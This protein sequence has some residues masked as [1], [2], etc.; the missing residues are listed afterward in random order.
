MWELG[1][2]CI[3]YDPNIHDTASKF[4]RCDSAV[5]SGVVLMLFACIVWLKL[6]SYAHTSYDMRAVAKSSLDK[7]MTR[8]PYCSIVF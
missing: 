4:C 6:V 8:S 1:S 3:T 7:V 5:Q 2:Y